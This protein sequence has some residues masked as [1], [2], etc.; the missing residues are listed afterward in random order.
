[1]KTRNL[2]TAA[3][4]TFGLSA[5]AQAAPNGL[6]NL[7]TRLVSSAVTVTAEEISNEVTE[8]VLNKAYHFNTEAP[9]TSVEI[10]DM[11]ALEKNEQVDTEQ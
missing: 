11:S 2:I 9:K 10:T 7:L 1:M 5:S 6:E 3:V 4:F 8:T